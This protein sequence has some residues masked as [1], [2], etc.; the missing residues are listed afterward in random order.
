MPLRI[1]APSD[2]RIFTAHGLES[3][4]SLHCVADARN[5]RLLHPRERMS[6]NPHVHST[7]SMPQEYT[8]NITH[9]T[10]EAISVIIRW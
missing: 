8:C 2:T 6:A 7:M 10:E 9:P 3:E 4:N 5:T 1:T